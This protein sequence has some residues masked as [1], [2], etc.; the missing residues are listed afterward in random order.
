MTAHHAVLHTEWDHAPR[1]VAALAGPL[2]A[3]RTGAISDALRP[4]ALLRNA[5]S[6]AGV[7]PAFLDALVTGLRT[8]RWDDA[9]AAFGAAADEDVLFF[10]G[11]MRPA[12]GAPAR[13]GMVYAVRD[14]TAAAPVPH[15]ER[16]AADLGRLM[17]GF[18]CSFRGRHVEYYRLQ[19]VAGGPVTGRNCPIALFTPFQLDG[20]ADTEL[21]SA[22]RRTVLWSNVVVDR[23]R[24]V[25]QRAATD[26][27]TVD[28][29]V[30]A[31]L[32]A[33][34]SELAEAVG[35]W[36]THH[37]L[38]HGSGPLPLFEPG[39]RKEEAGPA[40][41][42]VEEFRVD[43]STLLALAFAAPHSRPHRLAAELILTE[44]LL[45]SARAGL[46]RL[47]T[48]RR[49]T[50]DGA[51]GLLWLGVVHASGALRPR[52]GGVG[53]DLDWKSTTEAVTAALEEIYR[54]ESELVDDPTGRAAGLRRS[55]VRL[56]ETVRPHGRAG[57][58]L[59]GRISDDVPYAAVLAGGPT[60]TS[61]T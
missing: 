28:G 59:L 30:P 50:A 36:L 57:G 4:G 7:A 45:R 17:F 24:A 53:A 5:L 51:H 9:V 38:F 42:S 27:L 16:S 39:S 23:H 6:A 19:A 41:Y 11:P 12:E 20:W 25:A 1:A 56:H 2:A 48:G 46:A 22:R 3:G 61:P 18:P 34:P 52:A 29:S 40:Y 49:P 8:G 43:A 58:D 32:S 33:S 54:A 60:A 10:V 37:E 26:F 13:L 15:I 44:R 35:L 14:E 31:V 55:A 21:Q 47:A